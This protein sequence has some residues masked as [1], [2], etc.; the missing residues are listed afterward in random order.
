MSKIHDALHMRR[1]FSGDRQSTLVDVRCEAYWA[2]RSKLKGFEVE[3]L[4]YMQERDENAGTR[5]GFDEKILKKKPP[6]LLVQG[7]TKT[8]TQLLRQSLSSVR[9]RIDAWGYLSMSRMLQSKFN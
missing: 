1:I 8:E 5:E 2:P 7:R 6:R 4:K 9:N 3:Y